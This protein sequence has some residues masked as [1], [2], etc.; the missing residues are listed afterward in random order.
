MIFLGESCDMKYMG[1]KR[2]IAYDL[3]PYFL[4]ILENR[5]KYKID[6]YIEPFMGGCNMLDKI[7]H[8]DGI[9]KIASDKNFYLVEM[10][11]N[12]GKVA[13]MPKEIT[14][15]E[16]DDVRYVYNMRR[17]NIDTDVLGLHHYDDWYIGAVGFFASY[18]GRF[19]DG[20]YS[21]EVV[22]KDG[23]VRN[24]YAEA[25]ANF[26]KQSRLLSDVEFV[27]DNDGDYSQFSSQTNALIY[28]DIPYRGT[29]RYD[30]SKDFDYRKFYE[31][32]SEMSQRD[33]IVLISEQ[34]VPS[35]LD[36]GKLPLYVLWSKESVVRSI[37]NEKS[38]YSDEV[39]MSTIDGIKADNG[40]D[41]FD[42]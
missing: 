11:R 22:T 30:T 27:Y 18:N 36:K 15:K 42:L 19:F 8:I 7:P 1:S 24:Y 39:L 5:N 14:K 4:E 34:S 41:I 26:I 13:D 21:G 25:R 3:L 38:V 31:W 32:V 12:M 16:Y 37:N 33:N 2:K 28:C 35:D 40:N 23:T 17:R 9:K 29:K 20:G 6:K 10:F